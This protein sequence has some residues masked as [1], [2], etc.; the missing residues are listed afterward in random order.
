MKEL[1]ALLE[2][3]EARAS[4]RVWLTRQSH[5]ELDESR[6]V[7]GVAGAR[8]VYRRRA[9]QPPEPGAP[10]LQPK[11]LCFVMDVSGSM[12]YFNGYDRRLE[13]S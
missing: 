2:S 11:H 9:E 5:G 10:Q 4:E 12:Y 13:R 1:R 8:A 7:D 6:L 3:R